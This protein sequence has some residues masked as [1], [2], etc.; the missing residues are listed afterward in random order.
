MSTD[1]VTRGAD[2]LV[3]FTVFA[4]EENDEDV[5]VDLFDGY[6]RGGCYQH[7][8]SYVARAAEAAAFAVESLEDAVREHARGYD[9]KMG[10]VVAL[11]RIPRPAA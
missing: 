1:F 9:P 11:R 4:N 8:R 6:G 7:S 3:V 5:A 2:R 10:L